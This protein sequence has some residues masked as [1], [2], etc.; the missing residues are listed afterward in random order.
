MRVGFFVAYRKGRQMADKVMLGHDNIYSSRDRVNVL[1]QFGHGPDDWNN[2]YPPVNRRKQSEDIKDYL[3]NIV[4]ETI[5]YQRPGWVNRVT[6][7]TIRPVHNERGAYVWVAWG[8][9]KN[10]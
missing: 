3:R 2:H 9:C 5:Q 8:E 6:E 1:Y 4:R 7:I 10:G